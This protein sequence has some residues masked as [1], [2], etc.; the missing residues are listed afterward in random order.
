MKIV[1]HTKLNRLWVENIEALRR[2][3]LEVDFITE[4]E[5][6]EGEIESSDAFV[7]GEITLELIQ[8]AKNLDIIFVPYAGINALPLKFIKD[9]G[10]RVANVHG[11]APY[12]AERCIAMALTFYGKIIDYHDDLKNSKWHGYWAKGT[13][14]D[15][16]DSIQ[17]KTCAVIGVGEIGKYLAKYLKVFGCRVIGFKRKPVS[18]PMEHFDEITLDLSEVLETSELVFITLPLTDETWGMFSAEVLAKMKGKFLVNVGRGEIVDEEALYRSLKEGILKG[19]GIDVWYTYP[20]KDETTANPSRFPIHELPNVVLSPHLAGFTP[21]A[22][23]VNIRQTFEN[24]RT[25]I[26]TGKAKFEVD[27]ESMY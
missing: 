2:D 20:K 11:N 25:Y 13:A 17:G 9:H 16:W 6:I 26:E 12:V 21:Q 27:P 19:A 1:F 23:Q 10:I 15:T 18:G 14:N 24:I 22:A 3:F 8:R 4:K 7:G 5:Q